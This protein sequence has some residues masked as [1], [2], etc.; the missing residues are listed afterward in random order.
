MDRH[1]YAQHLQKVHGVPRNDH[2][3]YMSGDVIITFTATLCRYPGCKSRY[4]FDT[5]EKY[6]AHLWK[7]HKVPREGREQYG[8]EVTKYT[9]FS[10]W[11]GKSGA[12][13]GISGARWGPLAMPQILSTQSSVGVLSRHHFTLLRFLEDG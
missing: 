8:A 9:K 11:T 1:A 6:N 10:T 13:A 5:N 2:S 12:D 3:L 4:I 7:P